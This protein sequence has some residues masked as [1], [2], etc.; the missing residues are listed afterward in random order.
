MSAVIDHYAQHLGAIYAWMAGGVDAAIARGEAELAAL[1][2]T[3][4]TTRYAVDLGAGFGMHSIP[5]ARRGFAVLAIDFCPGLLQQLSQAAA[6]LPVRAVEGDLLKFAKHLEGRP[7]VVLCMGDTLTHLADIDT[8]Q[9]LF[10]A[11][12]AALCGDGVFVLSFRDY[13]VPLTGPQRFIPVRSDAD[14]ILTC[15]LDY[16][17]EHVIVQD[18]LHEREGATWR[19]RVSSYRKLRL[20]PDQVRAALESFGFSVRREAG[21]AGMVRLIGR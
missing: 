7:E 3:P 1:E 16:E 14:R 21:M 12:A 10:R 19:Q 4:Q 2:L 11:V 18:L 17:P 20:S 5:L 13:S 15:V 8:V 9:A 6:A